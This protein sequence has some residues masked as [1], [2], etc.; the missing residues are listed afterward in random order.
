VRIT[1]RAGP[2]AALRSDGAALRP[3]GEAER[4]AHIARM[5]RAP[6]LW[7]WVAGAAALAVAAGAALLLEH[8]TRPG[9]LAEAPAGFSAVTLVWPALAVLFILALYV[10]ARRFGR[11]R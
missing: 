7:P 9:R 4:E 2:D 5:S 1:T 6:R 10:V 8:F 3:P 11:S